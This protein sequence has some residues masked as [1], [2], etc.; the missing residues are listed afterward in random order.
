M[1]EKEEKGE[2]R[3]RGET[4]R[5]GKKNNGNT[6]EKSQKTEGKR[7]TEEGTRGKSKVKGQRGG[8]SM[9]KRL[10]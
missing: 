10:T 7:S 1:K 2:D 3:M 6:E 5:G 8:E 9:N 4:D